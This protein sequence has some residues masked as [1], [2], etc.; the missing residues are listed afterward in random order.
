MNLNTRVKVFSLI[1]INDVITI[2]SEK[3]IKRS[4]NL[5]YRLDIDGLEEL[6]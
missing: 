4:M 2:N 5:N 1:N 3:N 6:Q